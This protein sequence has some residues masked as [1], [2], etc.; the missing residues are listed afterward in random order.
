[1]GDPIKV[2]DQ[3]HEMLLQISATRQQLD[4]QVQTIRAVLGV[5]KEW[6]TYNAQLRQFEPPKV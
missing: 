4:A 3:T 1:M 6:S 5:P 2:N